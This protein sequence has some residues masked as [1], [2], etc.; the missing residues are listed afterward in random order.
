VLFIPYEDSVDTPRALGFSVVRVTDGW[1]WDFA[2]G[3]FALAPVPADCVR[4]LVWL[5]API[6]AGQALAVATVPRP[7]SF[8]DL[9]VY[10][11]A[12]PDGGAVIGDPVPV[13]VAPAAS[14]SLAV[15]F[16]R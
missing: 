8:G 14:L 11:H 1:A 9:A 7:D 12:A 10:F 2:A 16:A 6:H 13:D 3:V 15:A 5:T 4:P